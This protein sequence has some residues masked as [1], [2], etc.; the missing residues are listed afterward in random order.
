MPRKSI[1]G[2]KA[3]KLVCWCP[4]CRREHSME[5]FWTGRTVA[6]DGSRYKPPLR[7]AACKVKAGRIELN[8]HDYRGE[9]R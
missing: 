4:M 9:G 3:R 1:Y 8:V 7:C 6:A 2:S 5:I